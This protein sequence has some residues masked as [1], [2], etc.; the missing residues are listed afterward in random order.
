MYCADA[1]SHVIYEKENMGCYTFVLRIMENEKS[2]TDCLH[3]SI[4]GK[5]LMPAEISPL[6]LLRFH[7]LYKNTSID[8]FRGAGPLEIGSGSNSVSKVQMKKF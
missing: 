5:L 7:Y 3:A 8:F 2:I 6:C 1:V 4:N